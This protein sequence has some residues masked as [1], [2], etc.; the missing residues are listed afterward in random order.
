[1]STSSH[2]V[3][4]VNLFIDSQLEDRFLTWLKLHIQEMLEVSGAK[5]AKL[6]KV[7]NLNLENLDLGKADKICVTAQYVFPS[8]AVLDNYFEQQASNM[9]KKG[10]EEFGE[11]FSASRRILFSL[12]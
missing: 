11:A 10:I 8:R 9:R 6:F 3:Y 1:M 2:L 5:E 7:R 12:T 4:E